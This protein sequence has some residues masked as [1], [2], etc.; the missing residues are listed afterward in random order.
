MPEPQ[1]DFAPRQYVCYRAPGPVK[2]DGR[3]NDRAWNEAPWT[4]SF[5]DIEGEGKP[6]P[7]FK[8]RAKMLWD[9][10]YFYIAG[11][12]EEPDVWAILTDRDAVIFYDNDFEVFI[13]PD[14][15]T[16]EYYELEVN[17]LETEW[18]LFLVKPYRDGGPAVNAW[19]IQELE[20]AV[21][22]EGT[23]NQPGDTDEG[24]SIEIAIPW[25]VL[26]QCAHKDAPPK[27]GDRWRVNFSRVQWQTE[28]IDGRYVKLTDPVTG[29]NLPEDNWVWSPQGLIN[30][31]YPEMWGFVQFSE[32]SAGGEKDSF[33]PDPV[34]KAQWA[35]R[36]LYYKQRTHKMQYGE[37]T[38]DINRLE[39]GSIEIDNFS[40]PPKI[41]CTSTM[42]EAYIESTD[43]NQQLYISQDGQTWNQRL[44]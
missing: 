28:V 17:A 10:R 27:D 11:E 29:K 8:T 44:K 18:D 16:H 35:L 33:A 19:D 22:V 20:T 24:W 1:I 7:R 6:V 39:M 15:D 4:D 32:K 2:I 26:K 36:K 14:G 30:M 25:E 9:D 41:S 42:F 38:A 40:W 12:M 5:I 31:H 34:E 21:H 37:Y 43:K 3:L 23:I 13:D